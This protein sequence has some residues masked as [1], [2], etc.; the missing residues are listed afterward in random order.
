MDISPLRRFSQLVSTM[1]GGARDL[2]KTFGYKRDLRFE[3][4]MQKYLRQGVAARIVDAPAQ[5]LWTNPPV[6]SSNSAK[7]NSAWQDLVAR[8]RLFYILERAD[9]LCGIGR[10]SVI[11]IGY[12]DGG[13]LS[14]PVNMNRISQSPLPILYLQPYSEDAAK[15]DSYDQDVTSERFGKPLMYSIQQNKDTN[16]S[17]AEKIDKKNKSANGLTALKVHASRI[18]H[19]AENTLVGELFG[20]PRLERVYNTLEDLE[21]VTGG[22]AET[23]WLVGNRGLHI[24]IDKEVE[25]DSDDAKALTDEIDEYQHQLRRVIR[26]RGAKIND[27]GSENPDPTGTFNVLIAVLSGATGIPRRILTGSEAGQLASNQ[28]R[29][30]WADRIV[31]R[32]TSFG[33]PVVLYGIIRNL[34]RAGFLPTDDKLAITIDWP[35]AY[36]M[37]PYEMAQT[38]AQHARSATNF[39]K[40]LE[41]MN[42]IKKGTPAK[43][44]MNGVPIEGSGTPGVDIGDLVTVDEARKFIGLDKPAITYDSS[45]DVT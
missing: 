24:D 33:N 30:N 43:T 17:I 31:E 20:S 4:F 9:K 32:R 41:T 25:L 7:W 1:F 15:I 21:K 6:I 19:I 8:L 22:A 29:A 36:T 2:Y 34:T 16:A 18:I 13:D 12:N 44:D 11:L 37:S 42:R 3:D 35:S 45:K 39:A 38:S 5:A 23:Y 27:L 26:T 28:D 10:Y 14:K 40:A